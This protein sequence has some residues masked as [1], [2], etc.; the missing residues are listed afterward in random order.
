MAY[1][2]ICMVGSDTF[3]FQFYHHTRSLSTTDVIEFRF[4]IPTGLVGGSRAS[5]SYSR[6]VIRGS[7]TNGA[8]V[9]TLGS[10][11]FTSYAGTVNAASTMYASPYAN[12]VKYSGT[13][14]VAADF[15]GIRNLG[16]YGITPTGSSGNMLDNITIGLVPFI[17]M[18][19]SRDRSA[20]EGSSP[21][22]LN[23]RINGRVSANTKIALR[24]NPLNP[25]PATSDSDFTIGTI[26]AGSFGNTTF[27][28]TTGS[29]VWLISVPAGDYDG[30]VI[31]ANNKG[32][33]TIPLNFIYDQVSESTEWAYF[34]L[35]PP[36]K[37]GSSPYF[38][39]SYA[40]TGGNWEL[41]DPT[42]DNSFKN[43]VV[44]SMTDLGPTPTPSNT[45]TKT[46]PPSRTFTKTPTNTATS[47]PTRT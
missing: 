12:W 19:T 33:L 43:G 2:R 7:T 17:D 1:Q 28:H 9:Q 8:A 18:G 13:H 10:T 45:P 31:P 41:A 11:T 27:T 44:Y 40:V 39:S 37:E 4:G 36:T 22:S 34:E 30:G 5:D 20:I 42:C 47:T 6:Q 25:G 15:G 3:D 14:T 21:T 24:R 32:G 26:S 23:I 38:N 35:A 46:Y 29:D 16:F